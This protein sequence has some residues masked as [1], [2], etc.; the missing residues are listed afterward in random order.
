MK[1]NPLEPIFQEKIASSPPSPP[2]S[3]P[4]TTLTPY[5]L[6]SPPLPHIKETNTLEQ[7]TERKPCGAS[8]PW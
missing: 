8:L 1:R 7:E 5:I 2:S 6:P 3:I 4:P